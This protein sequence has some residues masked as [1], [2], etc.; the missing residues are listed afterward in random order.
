MNYHMIRTDDML[1]GS[2]LRVVLFVSGCEN[3]CEGSHNPETWN[4]N[5]GK[6]YDDSVMQ[7]ILKDLDND[8]ISGITLSGGDPL[9]KDNV[10]EIY[11]LVS[12]IKD[13]YPHKTIWLYT[14]LTWQQIFEPTVLDVFNP[15]YDTIAELRKNIV[16]QCDVLVDGKFIKA[17]EDVNQPWV[18]SKNQKVIDIK[19][20]IKQN[21]I[22][23]YNK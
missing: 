2:G 22:V 17:L 15:E 1:N 7:T 5:S 3:F 13:N 21:E 23:L 9:Y 19:E 20:T 18:G 14:G 6:K 10:E 12:H 8:Y 11:R 16:M 4:A